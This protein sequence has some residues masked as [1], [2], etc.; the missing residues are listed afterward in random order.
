MKVQ[1]TFEQFLFKIS[2]EKK[3]VSAALT[4]LSKLCA[5]SAFKEPGTVSPA[6]SVLRVLP[7]PKPAVATSVL[8][9]NDTVFLAATPGQK[10]QSILVNKNASPASLATQMVLPVVK[11]GETSTVKATSTQK[12][13][14]TSPTKPGVTCV[15]KSEP[16][17]STDKPQSVLMKINMM[18]NGAGRYHINTPRGYHVHTTW[19]HIHS[20]TTWVSHAHHMGSHAHH[21]GITCTQHGI[22]CTQHGI[23]CTPH[24]ITC[25]PHG[26]TC[27]PHG[28][29]CTPH[30]ITCTPHGIT[31]TPHDITCISHGITCIPHGYHMHTT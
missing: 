16:I 2:A 12:P 26:I 21:M 18:T 17:L 10:A 15:V 6:A 29:T 22:T 1:L 19:N 30:G 25:T 14:T 9:E 11:R 20:H 8:K 3:S 31:C 23:T 24:G 5:M 27:T 28:I 13:T 4:Q 7:A